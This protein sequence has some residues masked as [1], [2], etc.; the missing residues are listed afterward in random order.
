MVD[1][2]VVCIM[3]EVVSELLIGVKF[4]GFWGGFD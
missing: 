1:E 4:F 3:D 2:V